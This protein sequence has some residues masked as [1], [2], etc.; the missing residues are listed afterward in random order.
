[1]QVILSRT[2]SLVCRV[3]GEPHVYGERSYCSSVCPPS[4]SPSLG[5]SPFQR[6]KDGGK[7]CLA[8]AGLTGQHGLLLLLKIQRRRIR[9]PSLFRLSEGRGIKGEGWRL[10]TDDR[11]GGRHSSFADPGPFQIRQ[12][13][14]DN[15]LSRLSSFICRV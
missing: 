6:L 9:S 2:S 8:N 11:A 12:I 5:P 15:L 10:R 7:P 4:L 3:C 13:K 1:M 14:L